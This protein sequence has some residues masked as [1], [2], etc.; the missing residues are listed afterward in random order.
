MKITLLVAAT[1]ASLVTAQARDAKRALDRHALLI[2]TWYKVRSASARSN[3]RSFARPRLC[4]P[5]PHDDVAMAR[6]ALALSS[7]RF[8]RP[9]DDDARPFRAADLSCLP[10]SW[11]SRGLRFRRP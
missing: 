8:A 11:S 5:P 6:R 3:A 2:G 1:L 9:R 4:T 7:G 10:V